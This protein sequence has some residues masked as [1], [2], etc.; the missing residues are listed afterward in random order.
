[1]DFSACAECREI[2]EHYREACRSVA[3]EM[4]G[5]SLFNDDEFAQT[6]RQARRLETEED[7]ILACQV[8]PALQ[9]KSAGTVG[10]AIRRKLTHE[11]RSGHKIDLRRL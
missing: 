9:F 7:A 4:S 3:G 8:F 2:I 6:W 5:S 11:A 1:M 10:A